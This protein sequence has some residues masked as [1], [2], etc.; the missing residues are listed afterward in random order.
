MGFAKLSF[1]DATDWWTTVHAW[2]EGNWNEE[3]RR[4]PKDKA[5]DGSACGGG[6]GVL[7]SRSGEANVRVWG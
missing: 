4:S 2:F 1:D 7:T 6:V 5:S 3:D